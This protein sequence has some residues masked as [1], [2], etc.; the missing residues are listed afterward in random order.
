MPPRVVRVR[1]V[2][3]RPCTLPWPSTVLTFL[4]P[5]GSSLFDM[6]GTLID[7]TAGVEGA[8]KEFQKTYPHI[9]AE[10]V[11]SCELSRHV[12]SLALGRFI[13]RFWQPRMEYALWRTFVTIVA[14]KIRGYSPYV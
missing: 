12:H 1:T 3:V 2:Y 13:G 10:H 9:N 7:S 14:L 6:D 5:D 4:S 11:F 8:W